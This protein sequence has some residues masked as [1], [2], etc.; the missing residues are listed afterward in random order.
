MKAESE[1]MKSMAN[2]KS[3]KLWNENENEERNFN[4]VKEKSENE[5]EEEYENGQWNGEI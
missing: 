3:E 1:K 4:N 5:S 2:R